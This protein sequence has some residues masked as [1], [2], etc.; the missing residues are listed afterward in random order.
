MLIN[1]QLRGL[2]LWETH[3]KPL[4]L[5]LNR[6]FPYEDCHFDTRNCIGSPATSAPALRSKMLANL[7]TLEFLAK[8]D[9]PKHTSDIPSLSVCIYIYIY[10]YMYMPKYTYI[11]IYILQQVYVHFRS[12]KCTP[13]SFKSTL[14]TQVSRG[15]TKENLVVDLHLGKMMDFVSWDYDIPTIWKNKTCSKPPI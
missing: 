15:F 2:N 14:T 10:I 4:N 11:H 7:S 8:V 3:G 5:L 6:P 12:P 13:K 9:P 1:I